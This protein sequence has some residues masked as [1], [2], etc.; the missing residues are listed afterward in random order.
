[1]LYAS[2]NGKNSIIGATK[3]NISLDIS[4]VVT[5]V[6]KLYDGGASKDPHLSIGGGPSNFDTSK[7]LDIAKEIILKEL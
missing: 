4:S 3:E 2:I 1:M 5:Q 6:S 7:A